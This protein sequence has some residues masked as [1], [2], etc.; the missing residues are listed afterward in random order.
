MEAPGRRGVHLSERRGPTDDPAR[1]FGGGPWFGFDYDDVDRLTT[2]TALGIY[3]SGMTLEYDY[4]P[5]GNRI[6]LALYRGGTLDHTNDYEYDNLNRLKSVQQHDGG[7]PTAV[8]DKRVDFTYDLSGRFD[9]IARYAD[10]TATTL[11][12]TSTYGY[13]FAGRLTSLVHDPAAGGFDDLEHAW[14]YD[15]AN[16]VDTFTNSIDGLTDYGYDARDQLETADRDGTALDETYDYDDAGNRTEDGAA[17]YTVGANNRLLFDGAYRYDYDAEGNR[18]ARYVDEDESETLNTD[19]TDVTLYTWDHR[20]RLTKVEHRAL[21][22]GSADSVLAYTYDAFDRLVRRAIDADGNANFEQ[23]ELF[24]YDGADPVLEWVD[25]NGPASGG[26]VVA[27]RFLNGPA[28]DMILAEEDSSVSITASDRVLWPHADNQGTVRDLLNHDGEHVEHYTY[29]AFGELV[30]VTDDAGDPL[31]EA[32]TDFLYT[33]LYRDPDT[34]LYLTMTRWYDPATGR[35]IS[36]DWIGVAGGVNLNAYVGNSPTNANDPLGLE[37][38]LLV[39][40]RHVDLSIFG[41]R[42]ILLPPFKG[43]YPSMSADNRTPDERYMGQL[44]Y[45]ARYSRDPFEAVEASRELRDSGYFRTDPL[46]DPSFVEEWG[47]YLFVPPDR[48]PFIGGM[49][50]A[51]ETIIAILGVGTNFRGF[52]GTGT[53]LLGQTTFCRRVPPTNPTRGWRVGDP[54]DNLTAKGNV[55]S[56]D[57]VRQRFWKNEAYYNPGNYTAE[58]LARM[59]RGLAEQRLNPKTGQLESKHLHHDPPQSAGGLFDVIPMWPGDHRAA[60]SPGSN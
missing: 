22:Q 25:T 52:R 45:R 14:T 1:H 51:E 56:W 36:E 17:A 6:G 2:A 57:A 44:E 20:N 8:A 39:D 9:T 55:P 27:K 15:R 34:G 7:G 43:D 3:P 46:D 30:A 28:V 41:D 42:P 58:N 26:V 11:V 59:R 16:R 35:W 53:P 47:I 60:H 23:Y 49:S 54:I 10:L 24:L 48:Q 12:S 21:H 5:A 18:V 29:D 37:Q 31:S 33:G 32:G 38:W 50:R 19:D 4:D 13:D 40:L